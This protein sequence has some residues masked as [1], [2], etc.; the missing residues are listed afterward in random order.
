ML[1]TIILPDIWLNFLIIS[2]RWSF[3]FS[4]WPISVTSGTFILTVL[5]IQSSAESRMCGHYCLY[6]TV[7]PN[8]RNRK[9]NY[10]ALYQVGRYV[11]FNE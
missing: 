3:F 4:V 9:Q 8:N 7:L 5:K 6:L 1:P 2:I 10:A 11:I